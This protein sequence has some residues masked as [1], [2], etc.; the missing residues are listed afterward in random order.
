MGD[1]KQYSYKSKEDW[2]MQISNSVFVTNFPEH[3]MSR[4][5]WKVVNLERLIENLCTIWIGRLHLHA[6]VVRF[7][8]DPKPSAWKPKGTYQGTHVGVNIANS[9]DSYVSILK[10]G[11]PSYASSEDSCPAL[12][13]DDACNPDRDLSMS[14]MGKVKAIK[15]LS[16][17]YLTIEEEGFQNVKLYH[18]GGL[19]VLINLASCA[20]IENFCKHVGL[21]FKVWTQNTFVKIASMWGD[22]VDIEDHGD[23]SLSYKRLCLRTKTDDIISEKFK[24][25]M[26]GKKYW[27]RAKE[28]EAWVL[29][30]H[31]KSFDSS[32]SDDESLGPVH[33]NINKH[34]EEEVQSKDPFNIYDL[35]Q[36]NKE[37]VGQSLEEDPQYP[38]GFTSVENDAEKGDA[39]YADNFDEPLST[40]SGNKNDSGSSK[41]SMPQRSVNL[42]SKVH[43]RDLF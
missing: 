38:S 17:L 32:S 26:K 8:R 30:F 40:N 19:W 11:N 13:L 2:T 25:I 42:F 41:G 18:L 35:L 24:V 39:Q 20:S 21:P 4:D 10:K 9:R 23:V 5:L 33:G 16:N 1:Q 15:S 29:D 12:V 36:K 37:N 31:D 28:M 6:N 7:Q 22:L 43:T 27:I 14:L 34:S 3:F